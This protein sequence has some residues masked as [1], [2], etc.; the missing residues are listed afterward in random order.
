[1]AALRNPRLKIP[2][3]RTALGAGRQF[4]G[5]SSASHLASEPNVAL[6]RGSRRRSDE[7]RM[8]STTPLGLVRRTSI[9][10]LLIA[11][12]SLLLAGLFL[13]SSLPAQTPAVSVPD[14]ETMPTG[15][16][17]AKLV[18]PL[19][20]G[21]DYIEVTE[22]GTLRRR[23][24]VWGDY[25]AEVTAWKSRADALAAHRPQPPHAFHLGCIFLKNA[26]V[27]CPEI[28]GTDGQ[29]L[30]GAF[31]TPD[32]FAQQ[33]RDRTAPAYCEFTHAFTGGAVEST[34]VFETLEGL[35]W[36]SPGTKPQWSCQAKAVGD[37][38]EKALAKYRDAGIDMWVWCAGDP[39]LVN[40]APGAKMSGPPLGVSY[41]QWQIFGAFNLA[42]CAPRLPVVIHEVNHR[43]LDNLRDIEGLQLTLFHALSAMGYEREDLGYPDLLGTYRAVYLDIIRPA[44]WERFSLTA[45][46]RPTPEPFT[47][48]FYQWSDVSDDCWFRL[49][50]LTEKN[51]AAL[52]GLNGLKFVANKGVRWRQ[53]TVSEMDHFR[54]RSPYRPSADEK[55]TELNNV[56]SLGT[57][58]CA[59]LRTP[60]GHWLIV[61]PE[62]VDAYVGMLSRRGRGP[63][64]LVAGWLN[65]GVCPLLVLRAPPELPVPR[66]EIDYFR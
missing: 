36:T 49:P 53:F 30:R 6:G 65:D 3:G 57:E 18:E 15:P 8:S 50:L 33:M 56:L 48:R 51:L 20:I 12:P 47:G 23:Y 43:Y 34:W 4:S 31:S 62:V 24:R 14:G 59:V 5:F 54:L 42:I 40:G 37:Q 16:Y 45:H 10:R 41:T 1:V 32:A 21:D 29:P 64:L 17:A 58:S 11:V 19:K 27:I 13:S 63:P 55:D 46:P 2:R 35:T 28:R 26:T 61:R 52:T 38:L 66:R 60:T 39:E 44:M 25:S 22:A 7:F 9:F